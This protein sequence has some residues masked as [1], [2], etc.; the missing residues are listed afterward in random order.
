ME[1]LSILLVV[2]LLGVIVWLAIKVLKMKARFGPIVDQ[3]AELKRGQAE[4]DKKWREMEALEKQ[5][6]D[7]RGVY[8]RL[9]GEVSLLEENLE[10]ISFGL[11]KPHFNYDDPEK[12]KAALT[13]VY[14]QK[15]QLIRDG[16]ATNAP[17]NWTVNGSTKDGAKMVKQQSKLMLRAFNGELDAAVAKVNWNNINK[18]EERVKKSYEA[19][20]DAGAVTQISI[21]RKYLDLAFEEIRLSYE[22]ERKKQE[23]KDEQRRIRE[24]MREEEQ[25][26]REFERAKKAAEAEEARYQKALAA[27]RAEMEKAKVTEIDYIK[28]KIAG[29]EEKLNEAQSNV[30]RAI[31]MAQLTRSGYVYVISNI[32]SFGEHVFKIGMTRRLEPEER[33]YELG[34]ASVPFPYDI[35]AMIYSLDAPALENAFHREFTDR[36]VNAVNLRK[37]FFNIT[38]DEIRTFAL[39]HHAEIQFTELAEAREYRET[40]G[41]RLQAV[42]AASEPLKESFPST[43]ISA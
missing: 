9:K 22:L 31:S 11:Y 40:L 10:D 37:E 30:Q 21:T 43:L 32:G 20:N 29:L 1:P 35:H 28:E 15:K 25:A 5:Y 38:L 42:Q 7:A 2:V 13:K 27:A 36:R 23:I 3:D 18:M 16:G 33:I 39:T 34:S 14:D 12:F 8:E 41:L 26:Q 19:V 4:L 17:A 6:S 24:Q